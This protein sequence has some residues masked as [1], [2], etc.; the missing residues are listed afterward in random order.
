MTDVNKFYRGLNQEYM[1]SPQ[2][3]PEALKILH[4]LSADV[5]K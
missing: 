2:R 5:S 3:G 4:L 1:T